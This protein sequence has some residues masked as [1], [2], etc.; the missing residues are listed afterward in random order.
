MQKDKLISIV[1]KM[2]EELLMIIKDEDATKEQVANYLQESAQIII[3]SNSK[4]LKIMDFTQSLFYSAYKDIAKK[5]ISS[6][7]NTNKNFKELAHQLHPETI[8]KIEKIQTDM[9]DEVTKA[10]EIISELTKQVKNLEEK[11]NID[12]LTKV[13]NRRAMSSYL[14]KICSNTDKMYNFYLLVLDLDNFKTINDTHGHLA[15]DKVLIFVGNILKK[16][17]RD[18]DKIFRY[19]GEEFIIILNRI[20]S[21]HCNKIAD[22]LLNLIRSNKLIYKGVS[23]NITASIGATNYISKD[24]PESLIARADEAMYKAKKNGKDQIYMEVR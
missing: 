23:L 4:D 1:N 16:T 24:T 8:N 19:G 9:T 14:D 13:F 22:R 21:Q 18:G 17:L 2:C 15:G 20:D 11:S 7:A 6:Y 5:S 10:N 3:N 12:P